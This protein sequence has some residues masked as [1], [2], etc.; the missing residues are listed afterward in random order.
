MGE[1]IVL[2][3]TW[4]GRETTETERGERDWDK[5]GSMVVFK[6]QELKESVGWLV[7]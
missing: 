5:D 1:G 4:W 2:G 3:E 6:L 7:L